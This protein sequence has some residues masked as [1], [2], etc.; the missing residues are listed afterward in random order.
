MKK[1]TE[2]T[3]TVKDT[4]LENYDYEIQETT[5][6]TVNATFP[7]S[8][9]PTLNSFLNIPIGFRTFLM[10]FPPT[11]KETHCNPRIRQLF[12]DS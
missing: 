5:I 9:S 7:Q 4:I 2:I 8:P 11:I 10:P 12:S 3:F 1:G 6:P